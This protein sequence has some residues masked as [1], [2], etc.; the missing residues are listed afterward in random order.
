MQKRIEDFSKSVSSDRVSSD[1]V[2]SDHVSSDRVSSDR[3][4]SDHVSTKLLIRGREVES[5]EDVTQLVC[6]RW[7][8]DHVCAE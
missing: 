4:S 7:S 1:R 5:P 6:E 3:V 2:S 8:K